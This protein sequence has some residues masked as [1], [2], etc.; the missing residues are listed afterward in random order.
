MDSVR[1]P[2][3]DGTSGWNSWKES[4]AVLL[5]SKGLTDFIERTYAERMQTDRNWT[6]M[7][8]DRG[9]GQVMIS[10]HAAWRTLIDAYDI[11]DS[12]VIMNG[13]C[14]LVN[15]QMDEDGDDDVRDYISR[16]DTMMLEINTNDLTVE[17]IFTLIFISGLSS[18]FHLLVAGYGHVIP[19]R[20]K[21]TEIRTAA[22]QYADALAARRNRAG[23]EFAAAVQRSYS[24]ERI[25]HYCK[26]RSHIAKNCFKK[27][28]DERRDNGGQEE[29]DGGGP[30]RRGR[31]KPPSKK[32]FKLN[33]GGAAIFAAH[34]AMTMTDYS[35]TWILDSGAN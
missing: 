23:S 6:Q 21:M 17:S 34:V 2:I 7:D 12:N 16:F 3:F 30:R 13:I 27:R 5:R 9:D 31:A 11:Q 14:N 33:L 28:D 26:K 19:R 8:K 10:A 25:C 18:R 35:N 24:D 29:N 15:L 4:M 32:F 1:M 22:H 20:L